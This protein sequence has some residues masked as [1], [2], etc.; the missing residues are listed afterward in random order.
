MVPAEFVT[1]FGRD[2]LYRPSQEIQAGECVAVTQVTKGGGMFAV[3][4]PDL[5]DS[6]KR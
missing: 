4:A 5:I 1:P 3:S 2:L 6:F